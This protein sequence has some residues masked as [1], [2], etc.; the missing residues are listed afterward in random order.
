[1]NLRRIYGIIY[2]STVIMKRNMFRFF[3]IT[4][5]PLILFLSL[6]L[7][8]QYL[9]EGAMVLGTVILGVTGWRAVYHAQIEFSQ[10]YMDQYWSGMS[11]HFLISPV[12]L[13][14]FIIANVIVSII[15][16]TFVAGLYFLLAVFLFHH[17]FVNWPLIILGLLVLG[18]FGII[19]GLITLG[20]CFMYHENA[21]AV[22]FILPDLIVLWSG[23]YYPIAVFPKAMQMIAHFFPSYYGFEILKASVGAGTINMPWL[24]GTM[25][26][27]LIGAVLFLSWARKYTMKKGLFAKLN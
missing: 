27:W 4:L 7:F 13:G 14:E 5:W 22:S 25:L 10:S 12:T 24:I 26:L 15:K 3:D 23:V 9:N 21:F 6:T 18:I 2:Q 1:M 17:V 20:I 11:G 8:V 16:F 19:L